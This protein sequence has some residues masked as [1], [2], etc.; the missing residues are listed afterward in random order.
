MGLDTVLDLFAAYQRTAAVKTAVELDLFSAIAEG[1]DTAARLAVRCHA[2][3]R[4][5]RI[6]CDYLTVIGLLV[7]QDDRYA[8]GRDA[9]MFLDRHSPGYVGSV[10]T[11]VAGDTNL[12][13][14]AALTTAVRRGGT[15]L[16]SEGTLARDH[17][18]WVEFARAMVPGG[19]FMGPLLASLLGVQAGGRM[20]VLDIAAGHG[21]Y[22]IAVARRNPAAQIVALDWPNVLEVAREH[23]EAAGVAD[24]YHELAGSALT[25]DFG[26]DYDLVL[27]VHFLQDLDAE[28]CR[29]LL[30][31][32]RTA[33]V[34]EGRA[35]VLG[36]VPD[37][38]RVSPPAHAAFG[39]AML[40][41]TPG[42][43][44]YTVSELD[45]MFRDAGFARTELHELAPT[46]ERV[47]IAYRSDD[48]RGSDHR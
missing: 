17:P 23:A 22:G 43:D 11:S 33:L 30:V 13:A 18:A 29:R 3:E 47:V 35:V 19:A 1:A 39:L 32:V 4:G 12:R 15:A 28:A 8:L 10:V 14:F 5:L 21:L 48:S 6:L 2:A 9:A 44:A 31:K 45:R 7:K 38:G 42:G 34:S 36:F 24:R 26:E 40:A 46:T 25:V 16:P 27:L 37:D 41:T 20:R